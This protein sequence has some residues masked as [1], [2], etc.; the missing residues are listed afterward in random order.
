MLVKNRHETNLDQVRALLEVW[1][2]TGVDEAYA[3][4]RDAERLLAA[5]R[6]WYQHFA[7]P[8]RDPRRAPW[9]IRLASWLVMRERKH[10]WRRAWFRVT[11]LLGLRKAEGEA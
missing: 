10:P 1:R 4:I 2:M 3:L 5:E 8:Y 9:R 11:Q 6:E 7:R